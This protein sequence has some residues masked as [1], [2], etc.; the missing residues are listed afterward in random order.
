MRVFFNTLTIFSLAF[1]IYIFTN[2]SSYSQTSPANKE[3]SEEI[4]PQLI[5]STTPTTNTNSTTTNNNSSQKNNTPKLK[6]TSSREDAEK[7]AGVHLHSVGAGL[8]ETFLA[9]DFANH[10]EDKITLDLLYSYSASHSFDFLA[11]IHRSTHEYK[12][13]QTIVQG[14]AFGIKGKFYQFDSFS[15]FAVGGFGFYR[16][17]VTRRV[18]NVLTESEGKTA[19][20]IHVGAGIDLRL[21]KYVIIGMLIQYHDPFNIKQDIGPEVT[22][23]YFKVMMT[24]MYSFDI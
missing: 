22:G 15:P 23:H 13:E 6:A 3:N 2:T 14:I 19:F 18:N 20:G 12:G 4:K 11:D 7:E 16:P 21:N 1:L 9:G 24:G 10:G 8:G 5:N 17:I